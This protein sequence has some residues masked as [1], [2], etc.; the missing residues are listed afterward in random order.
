MNVKGVSVIVSSHRPHYI[1][2]LIHSL[3]TARNNADFAVELIVV[4]DYPVDMMAQEF[5][6]VKWVFLSDKSISR[7][8][9]KGVECS[10]YEVVAFVDDD[11]VVDTQWLKK[12]YEYLISKAEICGVEG[13][14][15]VEHPV[16]AT[17]VIKQYKR[18][19]KPGYRTNN[20]FYRKEKFLSVGGFDERFTVQREDLDLAFTLLQ[21]GEKIGFGKDIVVQHRFRKGEWWDLLKNC[22]NR[23][24]DPLLY[25]KHPKMFRKQLRSP[26]S[27]TL[28]SLLIIHVLSLVL[29][30]GECVVWGVLLI[31]TAVSV[32][33][34]R[35]TGA[36]SGFFYFFK[37]WVS[38]F[39]APFVI[40]AS[41][42]YG[43]VKFR[44]LL[45]V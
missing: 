45:F 17:S 37:E 2:D 42:I 26:F 14:T 18:L 3:Q 20:I 27:G 6:F 29:V 31:L 11:C 23:R 19:E 9:N 1:P 13:K 38:M 33:T 43:S 15:V 32:L 28:L 36:A 39:F 44:K 24:F 34:Y 40:T 25:K 7:K 22:H 8:R 21:K 12:G 35:R 16:D 41:L 5:G 30:F 4:A 10:K